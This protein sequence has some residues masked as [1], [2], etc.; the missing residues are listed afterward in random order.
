[1]WLHLSALGVW[2]ALKDSET[3]SS[4]VF[5]LEGDMDEQGA[6]WCVLPSHLFRDRRRLAICHENVTT[7]QKA[8]AHCW[9]KRAIGLYNHITY[10]GNMSALK[11]P[12]S[13]CATWPLDPFFIFTLLLCAVGLLCET[14]NIAPWIHQ[15]YLWWPAREEG[16]FFFQTI[17]ANI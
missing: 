10:S 8:P 12:S 14:F 6:F 9:N 4:S 7:S 11:F 2:Q 17:T 5:A 13:F 15:A 16:S 3:H 1:M